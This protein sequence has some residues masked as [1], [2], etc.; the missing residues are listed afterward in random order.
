MFLFGEA[1][2]LGP[3][4]AFLLMEGD[5][6]AEG[7]EFLDQNVE[8]LGEP[9]FEEVVALD[10]LLVHLHASRHVVRLDGEEFLQQVGSAVGFEGPHFHFPET[11]AAELRL[12]AQRLLGDEGVG[13]GGT[14]VDLFVNEVVQL[15]C[16]N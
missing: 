8:G 9:G 6:E 13:A 10:D 4:L 1:D 7:H 14:G 2:A 12:T 16:G 15:D 5:V 3:L 11:L